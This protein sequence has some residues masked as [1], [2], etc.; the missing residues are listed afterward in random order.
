MINESTIMTFLMIIAVI[1][2]VLLVIIIMLIT[3]K[4][5]N[6]KPKKRHKMST[7]YHKINMPN[8]MKLYLPKTIEKMS[9]KEILGITKKVYESY[10]IFDYKKMDLFELDKKEWHTWQISFLFM[11][12]KQD[13]EF[14]IPNQSEVFHPFLIKASSNDMKSFVKGLI[15][16]YENHVDISLDKDTLCKE[17]LWSNKD[18]SILFY[19]LANYKN[20]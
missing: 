8:T 19:F 6:K 13:Q 5:P 20:Y 3:Q 1:I 7:S 11:M 2:V 18:I 14:F 9:K 10:K 17:Y 4:K 15:K 12:Y 16:K